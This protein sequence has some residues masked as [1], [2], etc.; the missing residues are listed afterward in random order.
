M[1]ERNELSLVINNP[2]NGNFLK[3]IT[4]NKKEFISMV[5]EI[6]ERYD[7]LVYTEQNIAEAK[8]DRATLNAVK[9]AVSARRIEVK[10]AVM[11]PY[12]AFEK[13]VNE[14]MSMLEKPVAEIDNAIKEYENILR[15]KKEDEIRAY[16]SCAATDIEKEFPVETFFNPKWLNQ[17][18]SMKSIKA[19]IDENVKK[20]KENLERLEQLENETYKAVA[21]NRYIK[22]QNIED[23]IEEYLRLIEIEKK[24]NEERQKKA[25][26]ESANSIAEND[27]EKTIESPDKKPGMHKNDSDELSVVQQKL[28][29][30]TESQKQYKASFVVYGTKDEIFSV[31]RFMEE[32]GIKFGKA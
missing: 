22:S 15:Q 13:E 17:T 30:D 10:K 14:V 27:N 28:K 1:E 6:A 12:E 20:V 11:L 2:E 3:R 16:Y 31:R 9:K 26:I 4:W 23:A 7:N 8:K 32:R 18:V 24:T 19:E 21:I 25:E 5:R 29:P